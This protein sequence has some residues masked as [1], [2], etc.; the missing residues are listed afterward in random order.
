MIEKKF[1]KGDKK[2]KYE[3]KTWLAAEKYFKTVSNAQAKGTNAKLNIIKDMFLITN[4]WA[5]NKQRY[6]GIHQ[7]NNLNYVISDSG[8][9][10]DD[11]EWSILVDN[12]KG[13]KDIL[14]GKKAHLRGVKRKCDMNDE[15]TV[16]TLKWFLG[17]KLLNLGPLVEYYSEEDARNTGMAMEPQ[18]GHDFPKGLGLPMLEINEHQRQPMDEVD[19]MYLI[20]LYTIDRNI[21]KKVKDQCE[22]CHVQSNAQS[23]HCKSGNCLDE[24]FDYIEMFYKT[25]KE[26]L[27]TCDLVNIFDVVCMQMNVK[28]VNSKILAKAAIKWVADDLI[29]KDLQTGFGDAFVKPVMEM[30]RDRYD[31][32]VID[33]VCID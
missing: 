12:F 7:V 30:I 21:Q 24:D 9:N 27:N 22:A 29:L 5:Y 18:A 1:I 11:D 2:V 25:V 4:V 15:V 19:M 3:A 23:D 31:A 6:T 26:E 20:F 32:T 14:G 16:Y 13:I 10:L 28:L 33:A 8:V 17:M